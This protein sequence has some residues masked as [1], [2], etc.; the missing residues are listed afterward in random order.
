MSFLT[1]CIPFQI[2]CVV[3]GLSATGWPRTIVSGARKAVSEKFGIEHL[4]FS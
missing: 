2:A 4:Q 3:M 1:A